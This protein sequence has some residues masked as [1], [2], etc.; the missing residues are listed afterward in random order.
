LVEVAITPEHTVQ[1]VYM[2]ED[3]IQYTGV[4]VEDMVGG[5]GVVGVAGD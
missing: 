2:V 1:V 4:M 3:I 5:N